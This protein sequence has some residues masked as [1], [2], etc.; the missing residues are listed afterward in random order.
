MCWC[1]FFTQCFCL[2]LKTQ[3]TVDAQILYCIL[4]R[5]LDSLVIDQHRSKDRGGLLKSANIF[6]FSLINIYIKKDL[7]APINKICCHRI[8]LT[9]IIS[10]EGHNNRVYCHC[11]YKSQTLSPCAAL[12]FSRNLWLHKL[13]E[14]SSSKLWDFHHTTASLNQCETVLAVIYDVF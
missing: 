5:L 8:T 11:L 2:V 9:V 7:I 12:G 14:V 4:L 13:T 6:S 1:A 3:F 10:E